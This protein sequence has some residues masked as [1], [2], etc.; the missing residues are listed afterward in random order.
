MSRESALLAAVT[1][2]PASTSE[3]YDQVG[4]ATLTRIG[5]VAYD[6]FRAE[7]ARLAATG[8]IVGQPAPDGST[9][10]RAARAADDPWPPDRPGLT[11]ERRIDEP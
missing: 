2:E 5:L 6:A 4:Y 3:L 11:T 7:L 9:E 10:W 8:R 1:G